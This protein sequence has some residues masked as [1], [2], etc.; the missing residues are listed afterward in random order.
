MSS[1]GTFTVVL[2]GARSGKSALAVRRGAAHERA[3]GSVTFVATSPRIA[4]D[5]DLDRRIA[6]HQAERPAGWQTVEEET[7]LARAI[8]SAPADAL[9]IIDCLTLW[10]S[11]LLHTGID[12]RGVAV[13]AGSAIAA[14]SDRSGATL[15]ISNEVGLGIV[16]MNDLA[17]QYRDLLGRVNQQFVAAADEAYLLV[18]GRALPLIEIDT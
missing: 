2:G 12:A 7:D 14:V 11:N 17:R 8:A 3:G 4:G 10:V 6:T 13:A 5:E 9:V 1:R 18:A 16:P 15:V